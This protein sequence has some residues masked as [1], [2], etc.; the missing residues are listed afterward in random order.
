MPAASVFRLVPLCA[1]L[2]F[3]AAACAGPGGRPDPPPPPGPE[4]P[5]ATPVGDRLLV[6]WHPG[7][8]YREE[9]VDVDGSPV[10]FGRLDPWACGAGGGE[11]RD[12]VHPGEGSRTIP[13]VDGPGRASYLVVPRSAVAE[14][15]RFSVRIRRASTVFRLEIEAEP[16]AAPARP[17]RLAEPI[18]ADLDVRG[19]P[20]AS[21]RR[22]RLVRL[23]EP[24]FAEDLGGSRLPARDL[25]RVTLTRLSGFAMAN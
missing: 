15:V 12:T 14:P 11:T 1:V 3:L 24:P 5:F 9:I 22:T 6:P 16:V 2:A 10:R 23:S 25:L 4:Q 18:Y 7:E 21:E 8:G 13:L 20:A 17:V 19:C